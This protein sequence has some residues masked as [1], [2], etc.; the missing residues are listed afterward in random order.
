MLRLAT[1]D[2]ADA[3]TALFSRSYPALLADDYP[4]D[5][6]DPALPRICRPPPAL[7]ATGRFGLMAGPAGRVAAGGWSHERPG[8]RDIVPGLGHMRH[9]VCDPAATRRGHAAAVL[10]AVIAQARAA[11]TLRLD[12]WS[13]RTAVSFYAAQGF[14]AT[15]LHDVVLPG[16]V[17]FPSVAMTRDI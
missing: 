2:D 15:G 3:L 14:S 6:L 17:V 10:R 13:T 9:V 11:G 12:C 16:G 4:A 8:T 1:P 7:W 5:V